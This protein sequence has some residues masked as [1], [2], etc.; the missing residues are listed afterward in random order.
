MV[1]DYQRS[2]GTFCGSIKSLI[3]KIKLRF[4]KVAPAVA[5]WIPVLAGFQGVE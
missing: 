4:M 3:L 5:H 1:V 2:G